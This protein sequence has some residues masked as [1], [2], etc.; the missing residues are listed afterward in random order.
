[1]VIPLVLIGK[2]WHNLCCRETKTDT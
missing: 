2:R 1:M